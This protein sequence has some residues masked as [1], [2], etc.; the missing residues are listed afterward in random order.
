SPATPAPTKPS[1]PGSFG[2]R[3]SG[4][5]PSVKLSNPSGQ[6]LLVRS[7]Q[8]GQVGTSSLRA[9]VGKTVLK[10]IKDR[11]RWRPYP[12]RRS[13]DQAEG[14]D[15]YTMDKIREF[16]Q[17]GYAPF[18]KKGLVDPRIPSNRWECP[19][20]SAVKDLPG[21]DVMIWLAKVVDQVE[22]E[23]KTEQMW[24]LEG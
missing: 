9:S 18:F 19:P 2:K 20:Y 22:L 16:A 10:V 3:P 14:R 5:V 23:G 24:A 12:T 6:E 17:E 15:L 7:L 21:S 8:Y 13:G 11:R 1:T 4:L